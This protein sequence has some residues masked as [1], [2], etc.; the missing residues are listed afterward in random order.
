MMPEHEIHHRGQLYTM[1]GMLN[2]ATP[3]LYGMTAA[4]VQS[5]SLK[6]QV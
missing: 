4:Q 5:A 1:L 3:P 2:V 6:A